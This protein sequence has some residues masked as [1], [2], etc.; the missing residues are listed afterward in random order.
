M[1]QRALS[2]LLVVLFMGNWTIE[3]AGAQASGSYFDQEALAEILDR[4]APDLDLVPDVYYDYYVFLDS[5]D[6]TVLA[7]NAFYTH[8]GNGDVRL[9][10]RRSL[11]VEL[12]NRTLM[13]DVQIGDTLIVPTDWELDFRAYSPFPRFW[14]GARE[15]DKVFIIHKTV[16]AFAA[17]EYGVLKRWGP[18]NTG[19]KESPTPNGRFNFNW[20]EPFRVSSLSPRDEPWEMY[21]VLNFHQS[22][23]IHIHQYAFP[24]GGPT[25]HGCVR[26]IDA[27]AQ[28]VYNWAD[29][30]RTTNGDRFASNGARIIS[31]GTMVLVL[32]E[33]PADKP[34]PFSLRRRYPILNRID[35]P[36]DPYSVPAGT[37]QQERW[38]RERMASRRR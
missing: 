35:L 30:W 25:S 22:R 3:E 12:L 9:G 24:T 21:W 33:D 6:N 20:R 10:Q 15:I 34:R 17:Y 1:M 7:R 19:A 5:R 28:W 27:D 36:D 16:Q 18:V 14:P 4:R 2:F 38:D 8:I 13:Q 31:P 29:T 26:L 32:G 11:M 23:G 37:A